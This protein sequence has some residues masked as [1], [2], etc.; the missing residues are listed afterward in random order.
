[1]ITDSVSVRPASLSCYGSIAFGCPIGRVEALP[2]EVL[3]RRELT[4]QQQ[5]CF[6]AEPRKEDEDTHAASMKQINAS[7]LE[8][9]K[10]N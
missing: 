2:A 5:V 9:S 6:T 7:R 3:K 4:Q 10:L 1:M 8:R